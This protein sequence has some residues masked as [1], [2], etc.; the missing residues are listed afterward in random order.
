MNLLTPLAAALAIAGA[1]SAQEASQFD[2][3]D[4]MRTV[5]DERMLAI[6]LRGAFAEV[7][8]DVSLPVDRLIQV[9][10]LFT[11]HFGEVLPQNATLLM[12]LPGENGFGRQII[13]YWE[14]GSYIFVHLAF[15]DRGDA[16]F[17]VLQMNVAGTYGEIVS[18]L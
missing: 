10:Q 8:P 18:H 15:H 5:L 1:A 13:A 12:D 14:G 17:I 3:Y 11:S 4:A 7:L 6:D 9:E 16:G 2:D